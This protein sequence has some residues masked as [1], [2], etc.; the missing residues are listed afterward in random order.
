MKQLATERCRDNIIKRIREA[1][2]NGE[3]SVEVQFWGD[4]DDTRE[5]RQYLKDAGFKLD[6]RN[7][8]KFCIVR[9]DG[10]VY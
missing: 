3:F 9:W 7:N 8:L 10:K 6:F 5:T 2:E 4:W 1:S